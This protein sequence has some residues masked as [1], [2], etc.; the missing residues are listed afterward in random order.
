[1]IKLPAVCLIQKKIIRQRRRNYGILNLNTWTFMTL[2]CGL[3]VMD[4]RKL[5]EQHA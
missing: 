5:L 3:G 1:M 2:V 4:K